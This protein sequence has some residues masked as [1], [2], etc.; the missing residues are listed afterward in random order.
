MVTTF[1]SLFL[2]AFFAITYPASAAT[3]LPSAPIYSDASFGLCPP[4]APSELS[5]SK[6]GPVSGIKKPWE[7]LQ[8]D[9]AE[10]NRL[11]KVRIGANAKFIDQKLYLSP[12]S[13]KFLFDLFASTSSGFDIDS[14]SSA[15]DLKKFFINNGVDLP[16]ITKW[17][18]SAPLMKDVP[19]PKNFSGPVVE[20][21]VD[22]LESDVVK[23]LTF[24]KL[25]AEELQAFQPG[26]TLEDIAA[27]NN[28]KTPKGADDVAYDV[29]VHPI[30]SQDVPSE[31][32]LDGEPT[33]ASPA[34]LEAIDAVTRTLW[35]EVRSCAELDLPQYE[36]VGRV[37]AERAFDV[38]KAMI[39]PMSTK[40][41]GLHDFGRP[42]HIDLEPAVQVISKPL[43]FSI[44]NTSI[45]EYLSLDNLNS[46]RSSNIPNVPIAV[47]RPQTSSNDSIL[48]TVVCPQ[49]EK[50]PELWDK[51]LT[52]AKRAVLSQFDY[53]ANYLFD[54]RY[55]N[56]LFYTHAYDLPF[57]QEVQIEDFFVPPSNSPISLR[58]N[59]PGQIVKGSCG[60]FRLFI[61][62]N[63][64]TY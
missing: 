17:K 57:A 3:H 18:T 53:L 10:Y 60:K 63:G 58:E 30:H 49:K 44:W 8:E 35:G 12:N 64:G 29:W 43:Q 26:I 46:T 4:G 27:V 22:L 56:V 54:T 2:F 6:S 21:Y 1:F 36:A 32:D 33:I 28:A 14:K 62:K 41:N 16:L 39:A 9:W 51:A 34:Q 20:S 25:T 55:R 42:D 15:N 48:L 11:M 13:I 40:L 45:T 52:I 31:I 59:P 24:A 19:Y 37:I 38:K 61:P 50:F 5:G 7:Q 23:L 47:Q